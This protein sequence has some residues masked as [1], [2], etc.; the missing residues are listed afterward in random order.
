[1]WILHESHS[2]RGPQEDVFEQVVRDAW[3]PAVAAGE[4]ARFLA[5]LKHAH[6]TG[7][8]YRVVTLTALADAVAF[9]RLVESVESGALRPVAE[10]LDGLRHDVTGK[11]LTPLPW[12]PVQEIDLSA[13]S[14]APVKRPPAVYMEDTVHPHEDRLADYVEA[15]GAH[16][17]REMEERERKGGNVLRVEASFRTVPGGGRRREIVLWQ[18][19]VRPEMLVPLV[20]REVP[21]AFRKPGTWMHDALE[22][23]DDWESRLLRSARWSPLA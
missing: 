23:R 1:M 14:S 6:G 19:V 5:F 17:A 22:L 11:L 8:S 21:D 20:T 9:E 4:G 2:V 3:L 15:S 10:Q 12:S 13:I 7:A 16:Y 18:R